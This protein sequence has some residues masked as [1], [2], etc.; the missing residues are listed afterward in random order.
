M[1]QPK[2]KMHK[3]DKHLFKICEA[4][5]LG[6]THYYMG[7]ND[8]RELTANERAEAWLMIPTLPDGWLRMRHEWDACR[9]G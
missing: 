6:L 2:I 8:K 5:K 4:V 1:Y 9:R 7:P 3:I